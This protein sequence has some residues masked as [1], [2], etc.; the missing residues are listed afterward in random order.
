MLK[1]ILVTFL[2]FSN[3]A[4]G[5]ENAWN[6]L[7]AALPSDTSSKQVDWK[8]TCPLPKKS[9]VIWRSPP[10]SHF[11]KT[12]LRVHLVLNNIPTKSAW[13][14]KIIGIDNQIVSISKETL[15]SEDSQNDW[16]SE[17]VSGDWVRVELISEGDD[18]ENFCPQV[19]MIKYQGTPVSKYSQ[20]DKFDWEDIVNLGSNHPLYKA[21][22][23]VARI[24]IPDRNGKDR[25]CTGFMVSQDLMF[26]NSHCFENVDTKGICSIDKL[27]VHFNEETGQ[28]YE[29]VGCQS[30]EVNWPPLDIAILRLPP[31]P[32]KQPLK[33][34]YRI[35]DN[36]NQGDSLAI[37]QHPYLADSGF[38]KQAVRHDCERHG[39]FMSG[40][41]K[42]PE[43]DANYRNPD[44]GHECDTAGGSSGSPVIDKNN[45]V[46]GLHHWGTEEWPTLYN[47]AV[48]M[49]KILQW[50]EAKHKPIF[51]Q[52]Q[53]VRQ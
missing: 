24:I 3:A 26:T 53:I 2:I 6:A 35:P 12:W 40:P 52:L 22:R 34:S 20:F 9:G 7:T 50:L 17:K 18:L 16:W 47:Q 45:Y 48:A 28:T 46:V 43:D 49:A 23:S 29:E 19:D 36:N 37:I 44:F 13:E 33:L 41:Y 4:L 39:D 14:I 25:N 5:D 51:N 8:P 15:Q 10:Y 27:K 21:G 38:L 1:L 30:V 31:Q 42:D 32:N 11:E